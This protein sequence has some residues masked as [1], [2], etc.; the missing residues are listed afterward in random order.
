MEKHLKNN[1]YHFI[2]H[3]HTIKPQYKQKRIEFK[4]Y[5]GNVKCRGVASHTL[6]QY[7][8]IHICLILS[9]YGVFL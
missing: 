9:F 3:I 7:I 5:L 8:Y 4:L 1:I 2:P 6:Q